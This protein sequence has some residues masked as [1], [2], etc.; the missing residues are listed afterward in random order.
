MIEYQHDSN[1]L[2]VGVFDNPGT[3]LSNNSTLAAPPE[4]L[5]GFALVWGGSAWTQVEDHRGQKGYIGGEE[6]E[7][8][9]IGPLPDGWSDAPPPPTLE[10]AKAA[11]LA[12]I[13]A[14]KWQKIEGGEVEHEGLHFHTDSASQSLLASNILIF[15]TLGQLPQVWKAK[16]GYLPITSVDQLT[17][18]G[19]LVAQHVEA[20][21]GTEFT[22][23]AQVGAA[24]TVEAVQA[25]AWPVPD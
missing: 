25:I 8:K 17:A 6:T 14:A 4:P 11:K 12:E 24:E 7:I 18:I 2:F 1:G 10:A 15:Q 5:E 22:L 23:A 16:D 9:E 21:F 19:A 13:N 20:Q 3:I